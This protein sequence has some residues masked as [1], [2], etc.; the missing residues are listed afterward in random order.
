MRFTRHALERM[1]ERGITEAEIEAVLSSKDSTI[2]PGNSPDTYT[3]IGFAGT[4]RIKVVYYT[5]ADDVAIITI[6]PFG[7]NR[8]VP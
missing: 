4:R 6:Y 5:T 2:A 7:A 1:A 3:A 8:R